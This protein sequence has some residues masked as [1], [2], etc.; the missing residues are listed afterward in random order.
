MTTMLNRTIT[1]FDNGAN[2]VKVVAPVR[3]VIPSRKPETGRKLTRKPSS[4][5]QNYY[6]VVWSSPPS[7]AGASFSG[8]DFFNDSTCGPAIRSVLAT[9]TVSVCLGPG[10]CG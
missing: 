6:P 7:C 8:F 1:I 2:G 9:G 5:P 10:D 3:P 4:S